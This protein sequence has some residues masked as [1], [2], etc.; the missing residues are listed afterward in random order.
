[1]CTSDSREVT[2]L[3]RLVEVHGEKSSYP[4][5]CQEEDDVEDS[6]TVLGPVSLV[7][8]HGSVASFTLVIG[9]QSIGRQTSLLNSS[10]QSLGSHFTASAG[11]L[12][13]KT[14]FIIVGQLNTVR[15]A[16]A[17]T[18]G[19]SS[20][21]SV[22]NREESNNGTDN[23]GCLNCHHGGLSKSC[24]GVK[25]LNGGVDRNDRDTKPEDEVD[26]NYGLVHRARMARKKDILHNGHGKRTDVHA[27]SGANQD[28][29]PNSRVGI[30]DLGEA[31]F[32]PV[33]SKIDKQYKAEEEEQHSCSECDIVAP[34]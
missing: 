2:I 8:A 9:Q 10:A 20:S 17:K 5:S 1:M 11:L 13:Y 4:G 34:E 21:G 28:E 19:G 6:V 14:M 22:S 29:S 12:S 23:D 32:G 30:L 15:V 27:Q 18:L 16:E 26:G 31:V 7:I 24:L 25:L 3:S 33:M